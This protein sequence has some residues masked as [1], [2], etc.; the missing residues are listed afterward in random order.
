VITLSLQDEEAQLIKDAL[1]AYSSDFG[2]D[3]ADI[4]RRA[5]RALA[6][7]DNALTGSAISTAAPSAS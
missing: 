3:E 6:K 7:V 2:H 4:L 1:L 5:H